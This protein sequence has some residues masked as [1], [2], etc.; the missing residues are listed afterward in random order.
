MSNNS[1]YVGVPYATA[2]YDLE[3]SKLVNANFWDPTLVPRER[4]GAL[5][6]PL[7]LGALEELIEGVRK[8]KEIK[9]KK[10]EEA[11]IKRAIERGELVDITNFIKAYNNFMQMAYRINGLIT[12][13]LNKTFDLR[14]PI[15]IHKPIVPTE[16]LFPYDH[17]LKMFEKRMK[18]R[19]AKA[20]YQF[21]PLFDPI[22]LK[23]V[24]I[25]EILKPPY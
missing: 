9:I 12:A 23:M 15:N 10:E 17:E 7:S 1:V 8:V 4:L 22:H 11:R 6:G 19:V 24:N 3:A 25:D 20:L 16:T 18:G 14:L 2:P 5:D 21:L 13:H